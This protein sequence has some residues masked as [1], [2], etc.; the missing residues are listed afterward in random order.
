MPKIRILTGFAG[1]DFTWARGDII[2]VDD[3]LADALCQVLAD[4]T[5]RAE[6]VDGQKRSQAKTSRATRPKGET[7]G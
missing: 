1:A 2:D 5:R 3:G 7:R 4:G 6:P